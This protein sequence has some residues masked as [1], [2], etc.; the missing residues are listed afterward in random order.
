MKASDLFEQVTADLVTAI[1]AGASNWRMPWQRLATGGVPR[2]VDGRSYRGWNALVLAMTAA[3]RGSSSSMWATYRAWQRHDGQVRRGE[4]GTQVVLWKPIDRR[5]D[6]GSADEVEHGRGLFARTFTVFAAEQVDGAD[7][8][9]TTPDPVDEPT[10]LE[11]A[12]SYFHRVAASVAHGGDL[13][14][15]VPSADVIRLPELAR[16]ERAADYYSTS[17]HEHVHWTGHRSRLDRDL[18]GRFGDRAYG[19]EELIAELGAAF[20]CAQFQLEQATRAD[21]A[22][23]LGDWLA[24]LRQDA[25]ALV[26]ACGH[27]QRALDYLNNAAGWPAAPTPTTP[28]A[29]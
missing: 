23:Y 19:A 5:A 10:R 28:A 11:S 6:D 12:E 26:A 9:R 16:F 18:S 21:H 25:R 1:E 20:W 13:A 3:D 14:C 4:R 15:Y 22:A 29:A 27:A 7:I 24:I 17:A 2:S 8:L